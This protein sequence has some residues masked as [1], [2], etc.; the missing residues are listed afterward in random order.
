MALLAGGLLGGCG[1]GAGVAVAEVEEDG[2]EEGEAGF[3][4]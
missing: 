2:A 4:C 3:G 1:S